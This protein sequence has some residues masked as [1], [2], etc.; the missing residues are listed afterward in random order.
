M[1]RSSTAST[2]SAPPPDTG[3]QEVEFKIG[4]DSFR[5]RPTYKIIARLERLLDTPAREIG[6]RCMAALR[7]YP[8]RNGVKE[9]GLEEVVN[10]ISCIIMDDPR[11]PTLDALGELLMEQGGYLDLVE[12]LGTFL[13]RHIKGNAEY[14]REIREKAREGTAGD[15]PENPPIKT[16]AE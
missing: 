13:I 15:A 2:K 4:G 5:V 6:A 12:P 11:A 1:G 8:M 9:I 16:A 3:L 14:E 7:P 10:S